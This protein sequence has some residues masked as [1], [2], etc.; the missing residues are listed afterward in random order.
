MIWVS[1]P[2]CSVITRATR[3][4][5]NLTTMTLNELSCAGSLATA[6]STDSSVPAGAAMKR[7]PCSP[8]IVYSS[9]HGSSVPLAATS[10]A[11]SNTAQASS[12]SR[13]QK[14]RR[15]EARSCRCDSPIRRRSG[16]SPASTRAWLSASS[17]RRVISAREFAPASCT[18][19]FCWLSPRSRSMSIAK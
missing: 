7:S 3:S 13:S 6:P 2:V 8:E 18:R 10:C 9:G 15:Y 11:P 14:R 1:R 16:A 12:F 5:S 19:V 17:P 4:S